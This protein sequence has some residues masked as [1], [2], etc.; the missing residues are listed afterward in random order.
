[1][2]KASKNKTTKNKAPKN[3]ITNSI[4]FKNRILRHFIY[5]ITVCILIYGF[6]FLFRPDKIDISRAVSISL[7]ITLG[8]FLFSRKK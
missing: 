3:G 6:D 7:G 4:I 5:F 8:L 1:M 2:S